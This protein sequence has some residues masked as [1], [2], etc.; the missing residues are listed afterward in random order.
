VCRFDSDVSEMAAGVRLADRREESSVWLQVDDM[1]VQ[2]LV[3]SMLAIGAAD[4]AF[5]PPGMKSLHGLEVLAV[6]VGFTEADLPAR[7]QGDI[8]SISMSTK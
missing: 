8:V 2:K 5:S 1:R 3:E 4:S 7:T 6:D